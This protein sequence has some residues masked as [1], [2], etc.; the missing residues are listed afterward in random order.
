[1][2]NI[3]IESYGYNDKFIKHGSVNELYELEGITVENITGN[4]VRRLGKGWK[5]NN[6]LA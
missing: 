1:M 2:N 3:K 5:Q 6:S 4:I